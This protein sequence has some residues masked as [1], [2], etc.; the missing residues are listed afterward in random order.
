MLDL[1]I[2]RRLQKRKISLTTNQAVCTTNIHPNRDDSIKIR[3]PF[4][5]RH[6]ILLQVY[7]SEVAPRHLLTLL[8]NS[9]LCCINCDFVKSRVH[10]EHI[11]RLWKVPFPLL[12]K[13]LEST[14]PTFTRRSPIPGGALCWCFSASSKCIDIPSAR[15][16]WCWSFTISF[17][18]LSPARREAGCVQTDALPLLRCCR[19]IFHPAD[20]YLCFP[21]MYLFDPLLLFCIPHSSTSGNSLSHTSTILLLGSLLLRLYSTDV[22]WN[23]MHHIHSD[24]SLSEGQQNSH[25]CRLT[26]FS[27]TS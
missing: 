16:F 14:A 10:Q 27:T 26:V 1:G 15:G 9:F 12:S 6:S 2:L 5:C 18:E 24:I 13:R 3:I 21:S 19:V 22:F 8:A 4:P 25:S 11:P 23:R 7:P 17:L 20:P